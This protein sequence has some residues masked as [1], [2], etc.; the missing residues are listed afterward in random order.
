VELTLEFGP[1]M[2]ALASQPEDI[3]A[4]AAAAVRAAFA[5]RASNRSFL[6]SG[7]AWIVTARNS[8]S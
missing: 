6:M 2:L 1:L 4:R 3:R 7:A 5:E 8:A